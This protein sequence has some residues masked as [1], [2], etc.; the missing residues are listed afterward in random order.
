ML[1][2][3]KGLL[4]NDPTR[5]FPVPIILEAPSKMSVTQ[6]CF[7]RVTSSQMADVSRVQ[8]VLAEALNSD[9]KIELARMDVSIQLK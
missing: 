2:R 6:T 1:P 3:P 4:V 9:Q 7:S 5:V 8:R